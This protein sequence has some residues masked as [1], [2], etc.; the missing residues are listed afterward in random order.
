MMLRVGVGA[1]KG[2]RRRFEMCLEKYAGL[3]LKRSVQPSGITVFQPSIRKTLIL[4]YQFKASGV[5]VFSLYFDFA[6]TRQSAF[7]SLAEL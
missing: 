7:S 3:R 6:H 2:R 5:T 1:G 4:A